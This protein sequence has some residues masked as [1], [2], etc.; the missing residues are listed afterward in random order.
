MIEMLVRRQH[1][2]RMRDQRWIER[3]GKPSRRT[4]ER[5]DRIG[6]I[7]I[8]VGDRVAPLHHKSRLPQRPESH[9][10]MRYG[11]SVDLRDQRCI[12]HKCHG[13]LQRIHNSNVEG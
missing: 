1:H 12:T 6:Q 3:D 2:L 7:R 13:F 8:D 5:L 4:T 10:T 9:L 11:Q